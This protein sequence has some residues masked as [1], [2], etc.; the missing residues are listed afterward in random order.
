M[1]MR[2]LIYRRKKR[3]PFFFSHF[4]LR[5]AIVTSHL[6]YLKMGTAKKRSWRTSVRLL[7]I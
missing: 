3:I 4:F 7:Y 1:R 6:N 5:T 2:M